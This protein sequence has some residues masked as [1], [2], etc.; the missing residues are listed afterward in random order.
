MKRIGIAFVVALM[1]LAGCGG[2]PLTGDAKAVHD[3][4]VANG[5]VA[6]YCD[7]TTE[8]L[9]AK[10]TPELFAQVAKGETGSDPATTLDVMVAAD[11]ACKK[12]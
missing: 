8:E 2:P 5:G 11:K 3:L 1:A 10:M 6:S 9:Q 12:P 4:C 7:C